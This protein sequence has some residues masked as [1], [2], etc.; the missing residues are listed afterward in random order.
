MLVKMV[1][2]G[3]HDLQPINP[4]QRYINCLC[5]TDNNGKCVGVGGENSP[6]LRSRG[7]YMF[8]F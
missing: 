4:R 1:V 6:P 7:N 2:V 3:R 8:L 5:M